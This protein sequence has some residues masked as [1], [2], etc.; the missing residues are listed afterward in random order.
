MLAKVAN[1]YVNK[2]VIP[3]PRYSIDLIQALC[4]KHKADISWLSQW[5]S[6]WKLQPSLVSY[7]SI[8]LRC[9]ASDPRDQ[10][11]AILGLL[12]PRIRAL[13]TVDYTLSLDAVLRQAVAVCIAE[14]GNRYVLSFAGIEE[15]A[16]IY[17]ASSFGKTQ[18][19]Q[20]LAQEVRGGS[21]TTSMTH[22]RQGAH[23]HQYISHFGAI[24]SGTSPDGYNMPSHDGRGNSDEDDIA[25][26][27]GVRSPRGITDIADCLQPP[28][29]NTVKV[30]ETPGPPEQVLPRLEVWVELLCFVSDA[31]SD[32]IAQLLAQFETSTKPLRT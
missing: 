23:Q 28:V 30:S 15:D 31:S 22:L 7:L 29:G 8:S 13:F 12:E 5:T 10:G 11:F 1:L 18:F 24:A 3:F 20:Y 21:H 4:T 17:R 14:S 6:L 9:F 26:G 27:S 16:D 19:K 32:G 2:D 25:T